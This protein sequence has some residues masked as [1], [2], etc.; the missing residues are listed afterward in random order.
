MH[1][2]RVQMP[3]TVSNG[4][5]IWAIFRLSNWA[6]LK[7]V[8]L[9]F[10]AEDGFR[11]IL[12]PHPL[13]NEW[14]TVAFDQEDLA[15]RIQ[16][17]REMP[18]PTEI[19]DVRVYVKGRPSPAGAAIDVEAAGAWRLN[20]SC[21]TPSAGLEHERRTDALAALCDYLVRT[22]EHLEL[23]ATT[24]LD[25]GSYPVAGTI[26]LDWPTNSERP[27]GIDQSP[28][29][30]YIWHS[31]YPAAYLL[32]HA[33]HTGSIAAAAAA[34]RMVDH[35]LSR[36]FFGVDDDQRYVWY[37]HGTA[38]RLVTLLIARND[39]SNTNSDARYLGRLQ[40]AIDQ[41]AMLLESE[42]FYAANQRSR[43]HNHAWFQD[44]ALLAAGT[45][46]DTAAAPRWI[47]TARR[48]LKRQMTELL[49]HDNGHTIFIENSIGYHHGIQS[50]VELADR[51]L[52]VAAQD[53][54]LGSAVVGLRMFSEALQYRDGRAPSQGDTFRIANGTTVRSFRRAPRPGLRT[55]PDAGYTAVEGLD[56]HE[57]FF[58]ST[59]LSQT[60][61][62][63]DHLSMTL[64]F[65][66]VEW[67][68]DPSFYSHE[69]D[70][71]IP[72]YLRGPW[73]HNALAVKGVPY[74]IEPGTA[75]HAAR[76]E[77]GHYIIQGWHTSYAGL[78]VTRQVHGEV[79]RL[80]LTVRD[81]VYGEI[82]QDAPR[83]VVLHLGE[84]VTASRID[85]FS[86]QLRHASQLGTLVVEHG[87]TLCDIVTGW[88]S[89]QEWRSSVSGTSFGTVVSTTSLHLAVP[90]DGIVVWRIRST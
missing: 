9:G 77:D 24:F 5:G 37:D 32:I 4:S 68:I 66:G 23:Q 76:I 31:L 57:L 52:R 29:F 49:C 79:D 60:H 7:Y 27:I 13:Q 48:R 20:T 41:H 36:S 65:E 10:T 40:T 83:A 85:D 8:A 11:R 28:T 86:I 6:D 62:H 25:Q 19:K 26:F 39:V 74:S 71:P 73:A 16:Q 78:R 50:I 55:W 17:Q 42:A 43:F 82:P 45:V 38:E 81:C 90:N 18:G 61:K 72:K 22:N 14:T 88:N 84:H 67:L 69:Y 63:A 44:I 89:G 87:G 34:H 54:S 35:W 51:L 53:S 58:F 1:E 2:V 46:S 64:F 47:S 3:R 15:F 75:A 33:R 30:R 56:G 70:A 59:A 21:L 12:I 80:A